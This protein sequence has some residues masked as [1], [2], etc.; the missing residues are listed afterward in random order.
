MIRG[1]K[2]TTKGGPGSGNIGHAG[3]AGQ[4]GG[5]LSGSASIVF[6]PSGFTEEEAFEAAQYVVGNKRGEEPTGRAGELL[7]EHVGGIMREQKMTLGEWALDTTKKVRAKQLHEIGKEGDILTDKDLNTLLAMNPHVFLVK[8]QL[9]IT[10][11]IKLD[12]ISM[13]QEWGI[14]R[15]AIKPMIAIGSAQF[16]G[17]IM[18][19]DM[20]VSKQSE[21]PRQTFWHEFAHTIPPHLFESFFRPKQPGETEGLYL[22]SFAKRMSG[23]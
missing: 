15:H 16:R 11:N 23:L 19:W 17:D 6:T 7:D 9:T 10:D 4:S 20:K 2:F 8:R 14:S 13:E 18:A 21:H 3:L 22:D 5:S 1:L 12:H